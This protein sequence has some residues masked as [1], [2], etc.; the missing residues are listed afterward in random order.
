MPWH[1]IMAVD[2]SGSMMDSIIH[3]AV[4]A[5]IFKSLPAVRVSLVAFDTAVVDLTDR[6]DDP[7]EVLMSVHLGGGTDIAGVLRLLRDAGAHAA[8]DDSGPG[9]RLLRGGLSRADDRGDHAA[10][11]VRARVLGLAALDAVANPSYDR[12]MAER[13]VAAGAEVA[14]LTPRRLAEWLA[15]VLS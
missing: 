8:S 9:H 15:L 13:C 12:Q 3:S 6:I 11:R 1:I 5:G 4:M 14:A 7:V 2:C 10:P